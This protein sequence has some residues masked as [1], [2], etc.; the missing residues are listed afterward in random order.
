M[1]YVNLFMSGSE[2]F[3]LPDNKIVLKQQTRYPWDGD[4]RITVK[5]EKPKEFEICFR[6]PG[7]AQNQPVPSD[8]YRFMNE[9]DRKPTLRV[10]GKPMVLDIDKGFA[11]VKRTWKQGDTI[12][13]NLPMPIRRVLCNEKA[14]E[15]NGRAALQRGPVVYCAEAVDNGSQVAHIVLGD[16]AELRTEYREDLL[17]GVSVIAGKLLG[18]QLSRDGKSRITDKV[19]FIAIPC[20]AW[21]H[22]GPGEMAV[23]LPE[24]QSRPSES[25]QEVGAESIL[26]PL[27]K[28]R[29]CQGNK[30]FLVFQR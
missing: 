15:N 1:R 29:P 12:E 7:W 24:I 6:I 4:I 17:R 18:V 14:E 5:P 20:Y 10:N 22:R 3:I 26:G 2:T 9:S 27:S 21:A 13:L 11:R 25:Q 23:W 28:N 19:D 30:T 16:D 8:L